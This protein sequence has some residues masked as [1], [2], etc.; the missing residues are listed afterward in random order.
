ME[1]LMWLEGTRIATFVRESP[2][3]YG[4][5]TLLFFHALGLSIVVGMSSAVAVR[6]LGLAS[7]IPLAP[8]QKLYPWMWLGFAINLIS[9]SGLMIADASGKMVN[10][11]FLTKMAFVGL[12][13]ATMWLLKKRVFVD[14]D[15]SGTVPR[16]G[17]FLAGMLIFFWLGSI[18]AGRLTAYIIIL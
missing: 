2:S 8:L 14:S 12:A 13:I 5:A 9:G 7:N 4:Y 18:I 16:H 15:S 3:F 11:V 1:L 17:K 10:P 6:V